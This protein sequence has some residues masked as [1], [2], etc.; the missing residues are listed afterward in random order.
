M[1]AALDPLQG[2]CPARVELKRANRVRFAGVLRATLT[3]RPGRADIADEIKA[4][5]ELLGQLD[6]DLALPD[7]ESRVAH[8]DC[9][10][11]WR[12]Q[13]VFDALWASPLTI[14]RRVP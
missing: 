5:V 3:I 2:P 8:D 7:T 10:L 12:Q 13:R 4:S 6:C 11:L 14:R 9:P 1:R